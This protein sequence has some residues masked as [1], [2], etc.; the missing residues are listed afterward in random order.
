MTGEQPGENPE[1][2][3][4]DAS[5]VGGEQVMHDWWGEP[6]GAGP[7]APAPTERTP[8]ARRKGLVMIGAGAAVAAAAIVG[9]LALT[10]G[11][12]H[13]SATVNAGGPNTTIAN[14]N[15]GAGRRGRRQGTFGTIAS[16][17]GSRLTISRADG[18]TVD[19]T[20][21]SATQVTM[22]APGTL[23]DVKVGDRVTAVGT[24]TATAVTAQRIND[25]GTAPA[26]GGGPGAGAG[27]GPRNGAGGA[28]D[29]TRAFAFG[30]VTGV[31]GQ[32]I[33]L[34]AADGSTVTVT[35]TP[36]SSI[37]V[38]RPSSLSALRVGQQVQVVGPTAGDGTVTANRILEGAGLGGFRGGPGDPAGGG[39][40]G[41]SSG[42]A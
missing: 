11:G 14:A 29:P 6:E 33:T 7:A 40:P 21:T 10:G 4:P 19:V 30:T 9:A 18:S 32:T 39:A 41:G 5:D 22:S 16:I 26:A 17:S 12:S 25:T 36:T 35:T 38:V 34:R 15:G 28:P 13:K 31:N 8:A 3:S 20:T 24:G 27:R 1:F 42:T 37:T 23:A 2:S